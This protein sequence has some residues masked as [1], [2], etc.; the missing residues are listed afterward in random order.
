MY[1]RSL[2]LV[3]MDQENKGKSQNSNQPG[4]KTSVNTARWSFV[5]LGVIWFVFGVYSL[6]RINGGSM[7][8]SSFG[9]IIAGLMFV[10]GA[11][12]IWIG[13][14]LREARRFYFYLALLVLAGNILLTI[15]DEFGIYDLITLILTISLAILLLVIRSNYLSAP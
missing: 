2:K 9:W 10:N 5:I 8:L 12:L 14:E 1:I 7:S 3:S 4:G 11:V 6:I 15:T 13:W